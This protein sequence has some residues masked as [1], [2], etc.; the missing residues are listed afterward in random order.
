MDE[1]QAPQWAETAKHLLVENMEISAGDHPAARFHSFLVSD[2][3]VS[4]SKSNNI[5]G[6]PLFMLKQRPLVKQISAFSV[7]SS[8]MTNY[9]GYKNPF[10]QNKLLLYLNYA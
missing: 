6:F 2:F 8:D 9:L 1:D 10:L 4:S 5:V 3:L 7:E